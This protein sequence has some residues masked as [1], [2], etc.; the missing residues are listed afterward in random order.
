MKR[1]VA[2][3]SILS[4]VATTTFAEDGKVYPGSMGVRWNSSDPFPALNASAIHNPSSAQWLRLD[5][6]AVHDQIGKTIKSGWVKVIDRHY[7]L[8]VRCSLNAVVRSGS[9]F[10]GWWGPFQFSA[11]SGTA[12][13]TLNIPALGSNSQA[14]YYFS[15]HIPP[16]Y[17]GNQSGIVSYY[18]E[19]R[20]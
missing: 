6:P 5:L 10:T 3:L 16:T 7:S 13:Q 12:T 1:F 4:L 19:E 17:S 8:D 11:G 14:H 15:C 2:A 18:V 20:T 9:S